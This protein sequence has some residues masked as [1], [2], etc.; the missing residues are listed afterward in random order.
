[1]IQRKEDDVSGSKAL[2]EEIRS[3]L[4]QKIQEN[5]EKLKEIEELL[6]ILYKIDTKYITKLGL[7]RN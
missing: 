5:S 3:D 7:D 4:R 6:G 2:V 1:M